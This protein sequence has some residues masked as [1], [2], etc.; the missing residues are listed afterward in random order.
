MHLAHVRVVAVGPLEE[1][2]FRFLG[3]D[4]GPRPMRVVRGGAGVGQASLLSAIASTRP[5]YTVAQPRPR[6][7]RSPQPPHVVADWALGQD[8]PARPHVL[9]LSSPNVTL[10]EPEEMSLLR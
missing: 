8:D 1:I 3:P 6:A 7:S 2:S 10:D 4:G 5:G 9:R